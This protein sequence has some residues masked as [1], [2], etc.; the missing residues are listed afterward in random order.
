ML[1]GPTQTQ[2]EGVTQ[3]MYVYQ[4]GKS[5]GG[6]LKNSA[7]VPFWALEQVNIPTDDPYTTHYLK[8]LTNP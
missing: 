1:T 3:V 5:L 8:A 7:L 2:G 4:G 6:H